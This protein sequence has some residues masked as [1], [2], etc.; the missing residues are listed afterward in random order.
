MTS[1]ASSVAEAVIFEICGLFVELN[2]ADKFLRGKTPFLSYCLDPWR[3]LRKKKA[4]AVT[5]EDTLQKEGDVDGGD[6]DIVTVAR[7]RFCAD[8]LW[9]FCIGEHP[10]APSDNL[11]PPASC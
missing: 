10:P 4:D 11:F 6:E 9:L 8:T 7:K 3:A 5:P 1:S 2:I